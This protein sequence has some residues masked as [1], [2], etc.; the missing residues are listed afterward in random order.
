MKDRKNKLDELNSYCPLSIVLILICGLSCEVPEKALSIFLSNLTLILLFLASTT[1]S[2]VF[3]MLS[4]RRGG[5]EEGRRGGG[6][7][8]RRGGGEGRSY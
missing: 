6:E 4:L 7:G 2:F 5:G 8:G 1:L 3:R